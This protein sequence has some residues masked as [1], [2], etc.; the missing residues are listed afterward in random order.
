MAQKERKKHIE[1]IYYFQRRNI[2]TNIDIICYGWVLP[3]QSVKE[4]TGPGTESRKP[5]SV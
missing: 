2:G 4:F 5:F 3:K 1:K